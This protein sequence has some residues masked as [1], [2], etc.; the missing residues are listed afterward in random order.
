MWFIS[1]WSDRS[2]DLYNVVM[3]YYW[4]KS[5][6]SVARQWNGMFCISKDHGI[7]VCTEHSLRNALGRLCRV[8]SK[9]ITMHPRMLIGTCLQQVWIGSGWIWFCAAEYKCMYSAMYHHFL[10]IFQ[11]FTIHVLTSI[12]QDSHCNLI[13][14]GS[15]VSCEQTSR[16]TICLRDSALYH[17]HWVTFVYIR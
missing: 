12:I 5:E 2:L 15:I 11:T 8:T 6:V 7:V 13:L 3:L 14:I 9:K 4:P 17:H 1:H 10:I 16:C